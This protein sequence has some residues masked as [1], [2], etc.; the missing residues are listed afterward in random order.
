VFAERANPPRSAFILGAQPP[1]PARRGFAP[2]TPPPVVLWRRYLACGA[3]VGVVTSPAGEASP[4]GTPPVVALAP[5]P[6]AGLRPPGP[7]LWLRWRRP[8][9]GRGE[10]ASSDTRSVRPMCRA[11]RGPG[12]QET[13]SP[14]VALGTSRTPV[15]YRPPLHGAV[16]SP[17]DGRRH[18]DRL[19]QPLIRPP[20]IRALIQPVSRPVIRVLIRAPVRPVVRAGDRACRAADARAGRHIAR[21]DRRAA[22]P[23]HPEAARRPPRSA[24]R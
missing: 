1:D 4:S 24:H 11:R 12:A 13:G 21:V 19:G 16:R 2:R 15:R 6:P 5:R 23:E 8:W 18:P 14:L 22:D 9:R 7:I 17:G 10:A 3:C 20:V